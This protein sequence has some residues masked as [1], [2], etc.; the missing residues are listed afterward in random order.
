VSASSLPTWR[1]LLYVPANVQR[2]VDAAHTSGS[3][4][5]QLDLE[6]AVAPGEKV[7][8]RRGVAAA[9]AKVARGGAH[10]IVRINR[11]LALA[12]ED[13]DAG[14]GPNVGSLALP[15]VMGADHVRLLSE[16][17]AA[18]EA[19]N[20]VAVGTTRFIVMI[21]TAQAILHVREIANADPRI[22]ALT[23]GTEDFALDLAV[24]PAAEVLATHHA[25]LVAAAVAAHV[26][27]LGLVGSI[28]QYR[29]LEAFGALARRS[30]EFGYRGASCIHPTQVAVLNAAFTPALEDVERAR[31]IVAAYDAAHARGLGAISLDGRMIDVPI[32]ERARALISSYEATSKHTSPG[33]G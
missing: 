16:A 29:D 31:K 10:V 1:S 27:P 26:L 22:V 11:P 7:A 19:R 33:K 28:A 32:A 15:K 18:A 21:E 24:D 3:D 5:I 23:L 30:R 2:F 13:I 6:D 14:V 20:G 8:A 25:T 9:A 17:V 4:A 12:L